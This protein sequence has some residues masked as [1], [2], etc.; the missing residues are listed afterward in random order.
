MKRSLKFWLQIVGSVVLMSVLLAACG[1]GA[2]AIPA[3]PS[4]SKA[5]ADLKVT[6]QRDL[7]IDKTRIIS[8]SPD[9]KWL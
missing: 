3:P 7:K 8:L 2:V 6:A 5:A 1:G 4:A 9:G